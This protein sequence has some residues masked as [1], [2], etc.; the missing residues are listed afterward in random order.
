MLV[1]WP[2]EFYNF[3]MAKHDV[4]TGTIRW[5]NLDK[6]YGIIEDET[7]ARYFSSLTDFQ[8]PQKL[9]KKI[10]EGSTPSVKFKKDDDTSVQNLPRAVAVEL[11]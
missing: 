3:I 5:F 11:A 2:K 10:K 9:A 8:H 7:G 6:G 4:I 1:G